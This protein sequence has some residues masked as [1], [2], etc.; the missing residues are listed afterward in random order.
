MGYNSHIEASVSLAV[1]VDCEEYTDSD[2]I[3]VSFVLDPSPPFPPRE[4]ILTDHLCGPFFL[5]Q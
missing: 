4:G 2:A 1:R 5:S 3:E